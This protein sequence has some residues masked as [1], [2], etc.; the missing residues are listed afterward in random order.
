MTLGPGFE[1]SRVSV[2]GLVK[3][4]RGTRIKKKQEMEQTRHHE[5]TKIPE[6]Y[7]INEM[8]DFSLFYCTGSNDN[9]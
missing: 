1:S 9:L 6:G 8:G 2:D 4:S 7:F 3:W 5:K